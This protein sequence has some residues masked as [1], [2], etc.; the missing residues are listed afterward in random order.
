MNALSE[1]GD[2]TKPWESVLTRFFR[3]VFVGMVQPDGSPRP[4]VF[5]DLPGLGGCATSHMAV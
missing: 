1:N 3:C 2:S 5:G 4:A